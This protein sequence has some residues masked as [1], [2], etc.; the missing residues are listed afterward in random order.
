MHAL[1]S[2]SPQPSHL[3]RCYLIT[4]CNH[5]KGYTSFDG[6]HML[7]FSSSEYLI[8]RGK[9]LGEKAKKGFM[10][11]SGGAEPAH[12]LH[13]FIQAINKDKIK[14]SNIKTE[15]ISSSDLL[16][17]PF[18]I[19]H[20]HISS[21]S[22]HDESQGD[23]SSPINSTLIR[24]VSPA[25]TKRACMSLKGVAAFPP[26]FSLPSNLDSVQTSKSYQPCEG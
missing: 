19:K 17:S 2:D 3:L 24:S 25:N 16:N 20:E 18:F 6:N 9:T 15:A 4:T 12:T 26:H 1:M 14:F 7:E 22:E 5:N 21:L 8:P 11:Q 13:R 10:N 23:A